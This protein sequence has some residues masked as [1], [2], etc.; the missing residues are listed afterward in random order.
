M[1]FSRLFQGSS[2]PMK[3]QNREVQNSSRHTDS[4]I[5]FLSRHTD[6]NKDI[7]IAYRIQGDIHTFFFIR[8]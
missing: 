2:Y 5:E 8:I 1:P 6:R 3:G 7:Q 4:I